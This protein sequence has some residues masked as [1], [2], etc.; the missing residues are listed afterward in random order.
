MRRGAST[1]LLAAAL[2]LL[3][4]PSPAA[5]QSASAGAGDRV[6]AGSLWGALGAT[7]P[8]ERPGA[9]RATGPGGMIA[10]DQEVSPHVAFRFELS[11]ELQG[12]SAGSG[13]L[14]DGDVQQARVV[15][16]TRL[17]P[18]T[19]GR[20]APYVVAGIGVA[21]QSERLTLREA[22]DA[23]PGAWLRQTSSATAHVAL[24]GAGIRVAGGRLDLFGEARWTR[25]AV[26]AA[27]TED[28]GI[29]AGLSV[30]LPR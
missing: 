25:T 18:V 10:L 17:T 29:V 26:A 19:F 7:V 3:A 16:A 2:A 20:Y 28:L 5:A 21:W 23:V 15:A 27:A 11:G 4:L 22:S 14:L 6:P 8:L 12:L 24:L 13:T 30:P 1:S 9:D